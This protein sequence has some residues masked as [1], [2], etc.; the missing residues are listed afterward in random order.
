M[1]DPDMYPDPVISEKPDPTRI[2]L[3]PKHS[4]EMKFSKV[5]S[6]SMNRDSKNITTQK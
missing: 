4:T 5:V 1:P 6:F 3:N 2:I